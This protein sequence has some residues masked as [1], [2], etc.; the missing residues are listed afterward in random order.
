MIGF[1][2]MMW[3]VSFVVLMVAISLL[4][5]SISII[6]GKVFDATEDKVGYGKRLGKMCVLISFGLFIS[7]MVA[8]KVKG[9]LAIVYA[10]ITI[11]V[12]IVI[13]A[14]WFFLIQRRY[15]N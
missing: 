3:F 13:S 12:V 5:G 6:H 8:L 4:R 10:L 1:S 2:I 14:I 9:S 15:K 11:L 7:G